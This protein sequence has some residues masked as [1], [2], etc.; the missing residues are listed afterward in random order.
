MA[1]FFIFPRW[2]VPA[3]PDASDE[4]HVSQD[5]QGKDKAKVLS[6]VQNERSV[7]VSGALDNGAADRG[8]TGRARV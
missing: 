7:S 4:Y 5:E 2:Y 8:G 1:I 3:F 6:R